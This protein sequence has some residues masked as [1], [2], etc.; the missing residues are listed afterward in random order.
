VHA[1]ERLMPFVRE[2]LCSLTKQQV[3][4]TCERAGLPFAP[5]RKPEEL[6]DDPHLNASN[7]FTD[8]TLANGKAARVPI[9]P[10][11]MNGRRFGA[12]LDVP[13][14]GSHTADLLAELG[15]ADAAIRTLTESKIVEAEGGAEQ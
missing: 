10:L 14:L 3:M 15:Y 4:D 1:R 9:L 11:E 5:I 13:N 12:R 2:Q 6:F 7:G 8:I